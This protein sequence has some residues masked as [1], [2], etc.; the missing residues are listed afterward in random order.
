[1]AIRF[2]SAAT[3][4]TASATDELVRSVIMSTR[5]TSNHSRALLAAMS[6][7]FW[8]SASRT[9]IGRSRTLPPMSSTAMRTAV[10]DPWPERSESTPLMSVKTPMVT[11]SLAAGVWARAGRASA[12]PNAAPTAAVRRR[13]RVG[14]ARNRS[15]VAMQSLLGIRWF[16]RGRRAVGL[17]SDHVPGE[18][19]VDADVLPRDVAGER[20]GEEGAER[21]E[22]VGGAE[23]LHRNAGGH[24]RTHRVFRLPVPLHAIPDHP[25]QGAG[26]HQSG[27]DAVHGDPVGCHLASQRAH[28]PGEADAHA[29]GERHVG[30]EL[31]HHEGCDVEDP[32][33][34]AL[35]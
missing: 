24:R 23:A 14:G 7:L 5:F 34:T 32:S 16:A 1:M 33:E 19:T 20:R 28:R 4:T 12:A 29:V 13:R 10:S 9:T 17:S 6:A 8:W 31:L 22:V 27:Q 3:L 18:A 35:S 11:A 2:L 26:V 15:I 25:L 30:I 21:A